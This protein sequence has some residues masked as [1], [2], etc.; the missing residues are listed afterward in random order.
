[1]IPLQKST[2]L[3]KSSIR[4]G[5]LGI[6]NPVGQAEQRFQNAIA[7]TIEVSSSLKAGTAVDALGYGLESASLLSVRKTAQEKARVET[8][9]S[10]LSAK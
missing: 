7:T 2:F 8:L 3:E 9:K 1:M 4:L 10:R 6:T 5:G